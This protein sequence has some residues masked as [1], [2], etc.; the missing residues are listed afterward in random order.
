MKPEPDPHPQKSGPTHLYI[1]ESSIS[2]FSEMQKCKKA[3][4]CRGKTR[5]RQFVEQEKEVLSGALNAAVKKRETF[6]KNNLVC[7]HLT[8]GG[9]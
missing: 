7:L 8:R 2:E 4:I 5:R 1:I 9:H 6:S 3:V